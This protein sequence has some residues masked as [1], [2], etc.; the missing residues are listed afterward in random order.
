MHERELIGASDGARLDL[1]D[2]AVLIGFGEDRRNDALAEGAVERLVNGCSRDREA[3][4]RVAVD[5]DNGRE[6]QACGVG[7]GIT[8]LRHAFELFDEARR[9]LRDQIR[10]SA[11]EREAVLGRPVS[12]SM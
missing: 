12:A 5:V 11:F 4:R 7:G 10:I 1:D 6:P 9:P 2:D 3:R 8:Q